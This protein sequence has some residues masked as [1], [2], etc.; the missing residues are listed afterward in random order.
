M[1]SEL[2][3]LSADAEFIIAENSAHYIQNDQPEVV[4]DAVKRLIDLC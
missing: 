1:Q 2:L 4:I 3:D